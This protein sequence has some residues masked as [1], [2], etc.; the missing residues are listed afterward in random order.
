M[1][2]ILRFLSV[3]FYHRFVVINNCKQAQEKGFKFS[4]NVHGDA[5]NIWNCRSFWSDE[6]GFRY[7]CAE[8]FVENRFPEPKSR[9]EFKKWYNKHKLA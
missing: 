9:E 2:K 3:C 1:K 5:I 7:R 4:E 8:L 6:F